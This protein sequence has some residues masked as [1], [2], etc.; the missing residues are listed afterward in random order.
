MRRTAEILTTLI[1]FAVVMSALGWALNV[2]VPQGVDWIADR[3]G[4]AA[5]LGI[6]G[7]IFIAAVAFAWRG[8]RPKAGRAAG[9]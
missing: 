9:K 7:V 5:F 6:L 4:D 2:T 3:I 8:H 1:L